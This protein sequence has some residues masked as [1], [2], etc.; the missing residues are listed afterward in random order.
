MDG[1]LP[2]AI[3]I[4][5]TV[6]CLVFL[7]GRAF[8]HARK[9]SGDTQNPEGLIPDEVSPAAPPP[10]PHEPTSKETTIPRCVAFFDVETTGLSDKDR[11]VTFAGVKLLDT[12]TL[13][14]GTLSMEYVYLIFD[15][16]RKSHPRA[17]AIHGY[18]DWA[19]RH[20]ENFGVYAETIETF[21]DSADLVVAHNAEFDVGF[22]N[23][24]MERLGR[25]AINKPIFCTLNGYR[26]KGLIGSASLSAICQRIGATRATNFHGALEDAWLAMR[27][28]LWLNNRAVS[29]K[30]PPEFTADPTNMKPVPPPPVGPLP[31]RQRR[32]AAVREEGT[33]VAPSPPLQPPVLQ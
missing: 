24:E 25:P 21:F 10:L 18:S 1:V 4:G 17:E 30:L 8:L 13:S 2:Q 16:G 6:A 14:S 33:V 29:G 27:V 7:L 12:E 9:P 3:A 5:A 11:I 22:Y 31:R 19:L 23:R 26:Q 32:K 20:Q 28:Y 15:P